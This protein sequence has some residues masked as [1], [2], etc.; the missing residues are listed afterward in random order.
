M[1]DKKLAILV[2]GG[3][4]PGI[5]GVIGSVAIAARERGL[6][7]VGIYDGF[8]WISS[9]SFNPAVHSVPLEIAQVSRI[10]MEGGSGF[11]GQ[12]CRQH[13]GQYQ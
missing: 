11:C 13:P 9:S 12:V 8:K 3:P 10:H 6:D 5:N 7:V 2:G 4:A 1:R